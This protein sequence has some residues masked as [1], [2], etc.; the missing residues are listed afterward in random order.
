MGIISSRHAS[1]NQRDEKL[2]PTGQTGLDDRDALVPCM[3][4]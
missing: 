1:Y 2:L 4:L 3:I